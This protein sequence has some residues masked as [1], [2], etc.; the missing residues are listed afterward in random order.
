MVQ[1]HAA[2]APSGALTLWPALRGLRLRE[3]Q[4]VHLD[5]IVNKLI[6]VYSGLHLRGRGS[7][8]QG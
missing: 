5:L 3:L 2:G 6:H 7:R 1:Y 8:Q 4:L